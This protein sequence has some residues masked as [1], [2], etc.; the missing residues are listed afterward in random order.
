MQAMTITSAA[1]TVAD[2]LAHLRALVEDADRVGYE[3]APVLLLGFL[4]ELAEHVNSLVA[5][6]A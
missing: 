3:P 6:G 4:L 2:T 5:D 1:P